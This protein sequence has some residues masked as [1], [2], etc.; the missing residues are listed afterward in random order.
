MLLAMTACKKNDTASSLA[1]GSVAIVTPGNSDTLA[2]PLSILQDSTFVIE[3]S[4]GLAGNP[5]AAN[6]WVTLGVDTTKLIEYNAKYGGATLLPSSCYLLYKTVVE[7]PA[8]SQ[9]SDSAQINIIDESTLDAYTT[10]VLPVVVQAVDGMANGVAS[11]QVV[12][13]VFH[14]GKPAFISKSGWTI[15]AYSSTFGPYKAANVIDNDEVGTYWA[16]STTGQMPQ[17]VAIN[18]NTT[19]TFSAVTYY[20]PPALAYPKNGAY[21][22]SILIETSSDGV[23]WTSNGTFAGNLV[24]NM[25]TLNTGVT[26]AN[27]LRFTALACVPF[28]GTLQCVFISGIKLVP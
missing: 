24:N 7:L 13:L 18:F 20:F 5:S 9:F 14:T 16:S 3:L 26:T 28:I 8:G 21:P 17:Y 1:D 6:H 4:A 27:Y 25:Q 2:M 23:N 19:I 15:A 22:T 11:T 12:Y 10:Y